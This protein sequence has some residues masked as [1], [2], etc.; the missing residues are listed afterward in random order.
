MNFLK[1]YWLW[2]VVPVVFVLVAL[3]ALVYFAEGRASDGFIY[4]L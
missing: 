3:A 1:D 4:H 2:I